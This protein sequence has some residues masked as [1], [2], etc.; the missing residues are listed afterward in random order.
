[1]KKSS[2]ISKLRTKKN[3]PSQIPISPDGQFDDF[4][5]RGSEDEQNIVSPMET[6]QS[7]KELTYRQDLDHDLSN[8][9]DTEK[10]HDGIRKGFAPSPRGV[11]KKNQN[12]KEAIT[13]SRA[14]HKVSPTQISPNP[15]LKLNKYN[16]ISNQKP[17]KMDGKNVH[18]ASVN[19][20]I[21]RLGINNSDQK[22]KE[23]IA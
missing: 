3:N 18:V 5:F 1:M 15:Y 13:S 9:N 14:I 19:I 21:P 6:A 7:K 11:D 4:K 12:G 17:N 20:K 23:S 16:S 22:N 8:L 10:S 2:S